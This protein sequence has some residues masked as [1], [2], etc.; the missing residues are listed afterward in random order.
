M[1][2]NT[3]VQAC[4]EAY[5]NGSQPDSELE[6]AAVKL[7]LAELAKRAPGHAV[8]LRIPPYAAIQLI[9]GPRHRRG[10]PS[11]VVELSARYLIRLATGEVEWAEARKAGHVDA[12][13]ERADLSQLFPL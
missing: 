3:A 9:E 1:A 2:L 6:R 10:T 5:S 8:E 12:S 13:G 11:S 4:L 7:I